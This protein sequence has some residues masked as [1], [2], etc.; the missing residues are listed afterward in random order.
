MRKRKR[1][2]GKIRSDQKEKPSSPETHA[3]TS[4]TLAPDSQ[5]A[6]I[7]RERTPPQ[8]ISTAHSP[9]A[10]SQPVPSTP[11]HH[12]QFHQLSQYAL[13]P[14]QAQQNALTVYNT[15]PT[16]YL[17]WGMANPQFIPSFSQYYAQGGMHMQPMQGTQGFNQFSQMHPGFSFPATQMLSQHPMFHRHPPGQA[18]NVD[19]CLDEV[20]PPV[21]PVKPERREEL[22]SASG[23]VFKDTPPKAGPSSRCRSRSNEKGSE[24]DNESISPSRYQK[25]RRGSWRPYPDDD[26]FADNKAYVNELSGS[27]SKGRR[28]PSASSERE[29]SIVRSSTPRKPRASS[30]VGVFIN[31]DGERMSFYIQVD[32]R[33]RQH[34][35]SLVRVS[36]LFIYQR[37]IC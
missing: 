25:R 1:P 6:T 11:S 28:F 5:A 23:R 32:I 3:S 33:E 20:S 22:V 16:Q 12:S 8:S 24:S 31:S 14:T 34:L 18:T 30:F 2:S 17:A 19:A 27:E 29:V 26:E 10:P 13:P 7:K 9:P 36:D 4:A 21:S 15:N 37:S 35:L